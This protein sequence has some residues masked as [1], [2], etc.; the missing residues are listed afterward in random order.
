[1]V[2]MSIEFQNKAFFSFAAI[3]KAVTLSARYLHER[4]LPDKALDVIREASVLAGKQR[5]ERTFVTADDV[6]AIVHEK[7]RIPVEAVSS[8]ESAKLL[9][10]ESELHKRVIGQDAAVVAVAQAMRRARAELRAWICPSIRMPRLS[11]V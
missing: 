9:N 8:D 5:G 6:A 7:S 10:L 2:A 1:M 4:S 3:E 11:T